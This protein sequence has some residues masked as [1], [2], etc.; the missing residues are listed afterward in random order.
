MLLRGREVQRVA[1]SHIQYQPIRYIP[2]VAD[3]KFRYVC[4]LKFDGIAVTLIYRNGILVQG[5]T[6]VTALQVMKLLIISG[7]YIQY[8]SGSIAKPEFSKILILK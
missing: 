7:Q 2:L 4:E 8:H 3:E 5:A 6:S 1:R